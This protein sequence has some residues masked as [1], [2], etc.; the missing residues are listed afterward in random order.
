MKNIILNTY[1]RERDCEL[2]TVAQRIVKEMENNPHFPTPPTALATIKTLLPE[3]QEA[4]ANAKG[5][6]TVKV[7]IKKDKK[8]QQDC[9]IR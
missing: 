8:E 7:S 6:E 9:S 4:V 3:Y 1:K 5:R 2:G